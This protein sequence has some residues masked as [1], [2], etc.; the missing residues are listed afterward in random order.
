VDRVTFV[1]MCDAR[2]RLV[3][4]EADMTQDAMAYAIGMS[5]KTLVDIEKGRRTLGW[6]GAVALCACF[7]NSQVL[8]AAFD[9]SPLGILPVMARDGAPVP[10]PASGG[11]WWETVASNESYIIEQNTISQHYRLLTHDR[12]WVAASFDIDDLMPTFN[13]IERD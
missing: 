11:L 7:P 5:K 12:T 2:L 8:A 4:A 1:E 10:T 9:G 3:R 6:S 13:S